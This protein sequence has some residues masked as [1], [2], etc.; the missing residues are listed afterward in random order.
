MVLLDPFTANNDHAVLYA[1]MTNPARFHSCNLRK[2]GQLT[3]IL[4]A[5]QTGSQLR[6]VYRQLWWATTESNENHHIGN[7][8][9][10][11]SEEGWN[12]DPAHRDVDCHPI[13]M[14]ASAY[15]SRG[16]NAVFE[17]I[18]DALISAGFNA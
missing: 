7:D 14:D 16:S 13:K 4:S 15:H 18:S 3:N 10:K 9:P 2:Q 8:D 5:Q 12:A 1:Q 11:L 6:Y 17:R